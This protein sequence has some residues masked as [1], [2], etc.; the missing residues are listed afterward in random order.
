M[1]EKK[2]IVRLSSDEIADIQRQALAKLAECEKNT[3]CDRDSDFFNIESAC[4]CIL[5]STR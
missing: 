1:I 2:Q 3:G 4:A 5:L